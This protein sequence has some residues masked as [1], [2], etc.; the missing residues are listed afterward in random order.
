M[1]LKEKKSPWENNLRQVLIL[2]STFSSIDLIIVLSFEVNLLF[3]GWKVNPIVI[4]RAYAL[5]LTVRIPGL[6]SIQLGRMLSESFQHKL[7][8]N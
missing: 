8:G 5:K 4:T 3:C 7:C 6:N 1:L 2:Y